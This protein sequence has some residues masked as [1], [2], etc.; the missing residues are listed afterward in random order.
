MSHSSLRA[1]SSPL[2]YLS[3]PCRALSI[4]SGSSDRSSSCVTP[5]EPRHSVDSRLMT[6]EMLGL[7]FVS[8][9]AV[10]L[11]GVDV[12]EVPRFDD[13]PAHDNRWRRSS[14][15]P[16][17]ASGAGSMPRRVNRSASDAKH[18]SAPTA[19]WRWDRVW[20]FKNIVVQ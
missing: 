15:R 20:I 17:C 10:M 13:D 1:I 6:V 2:A 12:T 5:G 9:V 19:T 7:L 4:A 3:S 18:R 8:G 14:T 16:C 11:L